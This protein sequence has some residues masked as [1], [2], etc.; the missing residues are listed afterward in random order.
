MH[1]SKKEEELL[2]LIVGNINI[3]DSELAPKLNINEEEVREV[4]NTIGKKLMTNLG[5]KV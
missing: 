1:F 3:N 5:M 2:K 4:R